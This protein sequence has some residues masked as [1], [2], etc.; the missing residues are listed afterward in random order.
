MHVFL[1]EDSRNL[2]FQIAA[3]P[4]LSFPQA[5]PV[6]GTYLVFQLGYSSIHYITEYNMFI[7]PTYCTKFLCLQA[8]ALSAD[9]NDKAE[10][11][12]ILVTIY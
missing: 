11:K 10:G 5:S 4:Y 1:F 12:T 6:I 2:S 8:T 9:F 3:S 7:G